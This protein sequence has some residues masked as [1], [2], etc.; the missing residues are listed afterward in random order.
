MKAL[1]ELPLR[2]QLFVL[3]WIEHKGDCTKAAIFAGY[4]KK[5]AGQQGHELYKKLEAYIRPKAQQLV[6]AVALSAEQVL[7]GLSLIASS[8]IADYVSWNAK[9]NTVQLKDFDTLTPEQRYCIES[10]E[11]VETQFAKSVRFRLCKKQPALDTLAECHNLKRRKTAGTGLVVH[12]NPLPPTV[13]TRQGATRPTVKP[14]ESLKVTFTTLPQT[15]QAVT[16][17][18]GG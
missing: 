14:G 9:T 16:R 5:T 10:I 3:G 15:P 13:S 6:Q 18:Q 8:D 17:V 7:K 1:H 2:H 11:Q 4:S 12:I